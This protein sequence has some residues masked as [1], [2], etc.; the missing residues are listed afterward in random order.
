MCKINREKNIVES[1]GEA[2]FSDRGFRERENLPEW[3]CYN[4]GSSKKLS[5]STDKHPF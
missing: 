1:L 5:A 4:P 3:I 2:T